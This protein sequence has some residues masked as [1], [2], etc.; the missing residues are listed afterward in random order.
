MKAEFCQQIF[1]KY[2]NIK[3]HENLSGESQAVACGRTDMIA[4]TV[5]FHQFANMPNKKNKINTSYFEVL[6]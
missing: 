6:D 1:K 2:S 5:T 4:V 3:F